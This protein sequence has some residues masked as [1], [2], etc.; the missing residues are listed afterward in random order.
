MVVMRAALPT[1][2]ARFRA[3]LDLYDLSATLMRQNLRRRHPDASEEEIEARLR[4]WLAKADER[5]PSPWTVRRRS[6]G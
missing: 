4:R 5:E 1:V 2:T 3:L 6:S